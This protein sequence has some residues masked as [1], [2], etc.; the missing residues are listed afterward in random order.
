VSGAPTQDSDLS[1]LGLFE[2]F[3]VEI[4]TMIVD[5]ETLSVR[6]VCDRLMEAVTGSTV[7]EA[8]F[9]TI[10]WSNELALH[11]LEMKTNGPAPS[12]IGLSDAFHAQVVRANDALDGLGCILLPGGVH[13]WMDPD[14]EARLWPHEYTDVYHA[15]DRIFSCRGHGWANLQSTHVNLPFEGEREFVVLHAAIRG[16]LPLLPGLAAS[17]PILEGRIAGAL[18]RRMVEYRS[19]ARRVPSVAGAV[20]PEAVRSLTDY[21]QTILEPIYR[22]LAP[23][24]PE[25]TLRHEWVNGRG[26][27]ARFTRGTIEIRVLDPQECSAADIAVVR[28]VSRVVQFLCERALDGDSRLGAVPTG[29]LAALLDQTVREADRA[30]IDDGL[31]LEALGLPRPGR[32]RR[33]SDVWAE[34]V[35]RAGSRAWEGGAAERDADGRDPLETILDRGS[36]ARRIL[37]RTGTSPE[38][39]RLVEVYRELAG[40]LR[41]NRVFLAG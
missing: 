4:E 41:E 7:A 37:D 5:R 36:L 28:A 24:D 10:A 40:S 16:L 3:G 32:A 30:L 2:G 38:R 19:N 18:D 31:Y 27:I 8:E 23:L 25:G 6:P 13:P 35:E 17:S 15:F 22:D 12:L 33:T 26:A 11:V 9:G 14:S 39:S 21:Q 1:S 34:L 20:V 29:R